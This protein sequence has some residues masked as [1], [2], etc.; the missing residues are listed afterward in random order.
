MADQDDEDIPPDPMSPAQVNAT[1]QHEMYM[2]WV[3]A[4]FTE[5]QALELLKAFLTA[6]VMKS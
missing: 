5:H 6:L 1:Q 4:G 2:A 3:A